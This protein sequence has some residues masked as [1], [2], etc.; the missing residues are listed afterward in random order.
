MNEEIFKVKS[1]DNNAVLG[2]CV[3][4]LLPSLIL[5]YVSISALVNRELTPLVLIPMATLN[6]TLGLLMRIRNAR[7][8]KSNKRFGGQINIT[9]DA[10]G[11]ASIELEVPGDPEGIADLTE[12]TFKVN[13]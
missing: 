3:N 1:K 8:R 11:V 13:G 5:L 9:R 2:V 10:G 7:Y 6:V 12:I 4:I